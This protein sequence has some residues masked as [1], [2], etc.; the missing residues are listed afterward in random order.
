MSEI[1]VLITGPIPEAGIELLRKKGYKLDLNNKDQ[2]LSHEEIAQ[3]A[4]NVHAI[5]PLLSDKIDRDILSRAR[6]LKVIANYA[7]GYNNIDIEFARSRGIMVTN[8]PDILTPATAD[9]TWALILAVTKRVVEGDRFVR[10]GLFEGWKP[11][12]LLGGDVSGKTLGIIGAGRIGQ[13]VGRRA[14]GFNMPILYFS[15][16][17]KEQFEQETG[18]R[19]VGLDQLLQD[20]DIISLHC[21]ITEETHHLLN[22]DNIFTIKKGAYLINTAR[23]A[24]IDEQALVQALQQKHLAGAGLDVYE[25]EPKVNPALLSMNQVVLLPHLGSGTVETRNEMARMAARNVISV[26]ET[27]RAL[28]PVF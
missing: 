25:F 26:L 13:A 6:E 28:N 20:S 5:L 18:A 2:A 7:V 14:V 24:V 4:K 16:S 23:G 8:T 1:K 19:K 9:L 10:K 11:Q 17:R 12:L 15:R 21:P 22:T 27:G 3:R